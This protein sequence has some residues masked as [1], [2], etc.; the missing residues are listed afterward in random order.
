MQAT[1]FAE[2]TAAVT[3]TSTSYEP[4]AGGP[5]VS[6]TVPPSGVID[7][8]AQATLLNAS[9]SD[10]AVALY[11]D[12]AP[13]PGQADCTGVDPGLFAIPAGAGELAGGTPAGFGVAC[14]TLGAPGEVVF[15]TSPGAHTYGLRY[16]ASGGTAAFSNRRLYVTPRP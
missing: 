7:V 10:G 12:G 5:S 3:T 2:A 16:A 14:V 6:V 4:L 1:A 8:A 15:H 9:T 11:E 13:V